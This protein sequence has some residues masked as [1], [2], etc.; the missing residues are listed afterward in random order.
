[1]ALH[2]ILI[3]FAHSQLCSCVCAGEGVTRREH[4]DTQIHTCIYKLPHRR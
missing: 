3:E 1:M 4:T 2:F